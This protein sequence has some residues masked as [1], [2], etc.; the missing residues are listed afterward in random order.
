[1]QPVIPWLMLHPKYLDYSR[2]LA[3]VAG[4]C[5]DGIIGGGRENGTGRGAG[6][7][8]R[9]SEGCPDYTRS[10]FHR[11]LGALLA[12]NVARP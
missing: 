3:L 6:V 4:D 9:K 10:M 1:M 5:G 2:I 7:L 12:T 11:A 8:N